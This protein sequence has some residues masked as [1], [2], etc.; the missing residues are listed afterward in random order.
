MAGFCTTQ[1]LD[2][3]DEPVGKPFRGELHDLS[4]SGMAFHMKTTHDSARLLLGRKMH[5]LFDAPE[6]SSGGTFNVIGT[7]V[8]VNFHYFNEYSIHMKFDVPFS[9]DEVDNLECTLEDY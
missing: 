3:S 5:V 9:Q 7:V 6:E 4:C 8:G 1:I 2:H